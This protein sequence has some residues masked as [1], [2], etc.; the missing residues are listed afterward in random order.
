MEDT[1]ENYISDL[2]NRNMIEVVDID[3]SGRPRGRDK[4]ADRGLAPLVPKFT[5]E[6]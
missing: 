4:G 3:Y 6:I 2:I 1:G 5:L